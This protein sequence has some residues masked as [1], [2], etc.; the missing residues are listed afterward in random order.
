MSAVRIHQ[1]FGSADKFS[2]MMFPDDGARSTAQLLDFT[3]VD[4]EVAE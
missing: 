2:Q 1:Y 3:A 4:I